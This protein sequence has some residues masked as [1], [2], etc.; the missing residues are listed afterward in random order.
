MRSTE[1]DIKREGTTDTYL[2]TIKTLESERTELAEKVNVSQE[3]I[4]RFGELEK[5]IQGLSTTIS[6]LSTEMKKLSEIP[7]PE[8]VIPR[9]FQSTDGIS[10]EHAFD[11]DF[12]QS[13]G[14]LYALIKMTKLSRIGIRLFLLLKIK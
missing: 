12:P 11:E 5:L 2:T 4:D 8:I 13:S 6:V 7:Y 3:D 10:I 14:T 1:E 9:Y